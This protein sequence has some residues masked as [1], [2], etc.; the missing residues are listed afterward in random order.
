[1]WIRSRRMG[2]PYVE[3][4]CWFENGMTR[5]STGSFAAQSE[6]RKYPERVPECVF[7][8]D[9]VTALT[10]NTHRT[11]LSGIEPVGDEFELCNRIAAETRLAEA[12]PRDAIGDLLA[13]H[14]DL[15]RG[16]GARYWRLAARVRSATRCQQRQV[17]PVASVERQLL[18]LALIDVG[19][20]RRGRN[21]DERRFTGDRDRLLD[22]RRSHLEGHRGKLTDLQLHACARNGC[23]SLQLRSQPV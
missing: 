4:Y 10:I 20:R 17:E 14:V 19:R 13:V 15:E 7:V 9:F 11:T 3:L 22:R 1:M 23:K 18:H 8:P 5:S 16:L 21:V 12:R 2:P 6:S